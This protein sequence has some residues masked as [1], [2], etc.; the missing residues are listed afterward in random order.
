MGAGIWSMHFIGMLAFALPVPVSYDTTMTFVSM[1]PAVFASA[2]ALHFMDRSHIGWWRL[3]L[4]GLLM[5]A[6]I[7]GMHYA[8]MEAMRGDVMM[9]YDP[10]LFVLSLIVAH[11]LATQALYIKFM[12]GAAAASLV[13]KAASATAMGGAVALMHYTAMEAAGFHA[14]GS[15]GVASVAF[16]PLW[17]AVALA[18]VT[19]VVIAIAI[20]ATLV[21]RRMAGL[22]G[23]LVRSEELSRL[24]LESAGEGI[25]GLD[26]VGRFT[27]V[28][29]AAA[30]MLG[31]DHVSLLGRP[32]SD[33]LV[34]RSEERAEAPGGGNAVLLTLADGE[35][36]TSE[37]DGFR[38]C[39]GRVIPVAGTVTALRHEGPVAGAVVTFSDITARLETERALVHASREAEAGARAKSEFLANMSHEIRTPL[40]G[41]IGMT[42]ILLDTPLSPEQREYAETVRTS[43]DHLLGVVNDI[44]DFSKIEAGRLTIELMSFNLGT[45]IEEI[46]DV[47]AMRAEEKRIEIVVRIAPDTPR[48]VLGDPGRIRQ[49]LMNLAGNAV[50]FTE[51]GQVL[52]DVT[53]RESG[54]HQTVVRF[55]VED[56]GIGIEPERLPQVFERFTQAD[57]STTRQYGGTGLGL[58]I[59]RQLVEL[60]GG[61]IGATSSPGQGSVFWFDLPFE[62]DREN[63]GFDPSTADL[64]DVRVLIVDDNAVNRRVLHEQITS[65]RMRNGSVTSGVE[66]LEALTAAYAAG[67]PYRV[68]ILDHQMPGMDGLT[69]ARAIR[70]DRR[71]AEMMLLLLTSSGHRKDARGAAEAGFAAYLTKPV[72]PSLLLDA[73]AA[74]WAR[75]AARATRY[76]DAATPATSDGADAAPA[77][78]EPV[79]DAS[80]A[81]HEWDGS[82]VLVVEDNR[83]NQ[84][85]A[86]T[87]LAK[88]GCRVDLAAT[89]REA[90]DLSV[91]HPY[92]LVFM[93]CEM[94][95]M[96]GYEATREI[97]RREPAGTHLPI[98]AMTAH[99]L[100][101]DREKC[102]AA[103]MD[104]YIT[105]PM[106]LPDLEQ[107]L[108]AWVAPRGARP[109]TAAG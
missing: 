88:L 101:G 69:L 79:A 55:R 37:G 39:D 34:P 33:I 32:V 109:G 50:K 75:Q 72:R 81:P 16:E 64:A 3:N 70:S 46:A 92:V 65:W 42:G 100:P 76:E 83:V 62:V 29:P 104:D 52:I 25:F 54:D 60:M 89:G 11:L 17:M 10:L 14:G 102:L 68:A 98:V 18:V 56:T 90:V 107:A 21:D 2:M 93:D 66:A 20:V 44:L 45:A 24:I 99:A 61:S 13:R 15:M 59:S 12:P 78:P 27:F 26:A 41:V 103:G 30:R 57:A 8:G 40:N 73:L 47:L 22:T 9:S 106:R 84:K 48:R 35:T 23:S 71:L 94:P 105:K 74:A 38:R 67:D 97:R 53:A 6:G 80:S 36:R 5:A 1:V 4:G 28:N 85:V 49:V 86:S 63:D 19:S 95:E 43:A 58:T 96:D 82:R 77:R 108:A 87:L 7:G 31:C 51:T 91:S